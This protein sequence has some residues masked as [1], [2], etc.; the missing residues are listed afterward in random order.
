MLR[1]NIRYCRN[2]KA[3]ASINVLSVLAIIFLLLIFLVAINS[4]FMKNI[5][6]NENRVEDYITAHNSFVV[7]DELVVQAISERF[8]KFL[9]DKEEGF[10]FSNEIVLDGVFPSKIRD[11]IYSIGDIQSKLGIK[12][13]DISIWFEE[14]N[15]AANFYDRKISSFTRGRDLANTAIV[16]T[17]S[18]NT[19]SEVVECRR[20]YFFKTDDIRNFDNDS[21][22]FGEIAY[23]RL[24]E[25]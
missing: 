25:N 13:L 23:E 3:L 1:G 6:K 10:D 19:G 22:L 17:Y 18:V 24:K 15:E 5:S 14:F 16:V 11:K 12:I 8:E 7:V 2:K 9:K 4:L 20:A 21:I